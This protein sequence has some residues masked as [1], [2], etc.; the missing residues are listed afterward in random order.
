VSNMKRLFVAV[1]ER[2]I[3]PYEIVGFGD[4]GKM[5]EN[6]EW[7]MMHTKCGYVRSIPPYDNVV[8]CYH[9]KKHFDSKE[10]IKLKLKCR[11]KVK[12]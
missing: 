4:T 2:K 1:V 9:C 10:F 7:V 5:T 3:K 12:V 8:I 6:R 11:Q